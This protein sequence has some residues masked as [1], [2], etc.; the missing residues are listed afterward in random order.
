MD[1]NEECCSCNYCFKIISKRNLSRHQKTAT[2]IYFK[3]KLINDIDMK[4]QLDS[5]N[6]Q[7]T[8]MKN[9]LDDMKKEMT[10]KNKI[11]LLL[12]E[13]I[14]NLNNSKEE[15]QTSK[16]PNFTSIKIPE[17]TMGQVGTYL[18]DG[19]DGE[20]N[21]FKDT[22]FSNFTQATVSLVCTDESRGTYKYYENNKWN[23]DDGSFIVMIFY[24]QLVPLFKKA[25]KEL[26]DLVESNKIPRRIDIESL[27]NW[28]E[29]VGQL[30][31]PMERLRIVKKN[32]IKK[33][34]KN[35]SVS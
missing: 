34:F 5:F 9:Q 33:L 4:K 12:S 7:I 3:N 23:H 14:N 11:I 26:E 17:Y 24:D 20:I 8:E 6:K 10:D 22:Y 31:N 2:C 21:I 25:I 32:Q 35:I 19:I 30:R 29:R 16:R 27:C 18:D 15:P 1:I 13:K 28:N